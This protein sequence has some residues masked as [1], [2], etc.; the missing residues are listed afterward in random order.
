[1]KS[2][3]Q[4]YLINNPRFTKNVVNFG[5]TTMSNSF[6]QRLKEKMDE[7]GLKAAELSRRAGVT[8]QNIGRLLN[9]TPHPIT[10]A[11]PT[12]TEDTVKKLAKHLNWNENEALALANLG[13]ANNEFVSDSE[14]LQS[15]RYELHGAENWSDKQK[16]EFLQVLKITVAGIKAKGVEKKE[17]EPDIEHPAMRQP[18]LKNEMKNNLEDEFGETE[19]EIKRRKV[20]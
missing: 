3:S 8:K 20:A 6:A 7:A 14:L 13:S 15:V 12:T 2:Q 1:M 4:I 18:N 10:G 11:L 19:S 9:Q 16:A 17:V 5:F